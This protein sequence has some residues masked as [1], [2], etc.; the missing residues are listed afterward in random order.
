VYPFGFGLSYADVEEK[1]IDENTVEI[2]NRSDID[3]DYSVLKFQQKPDLKLLDFKK[4]KLKGNSKKI[5][6]FG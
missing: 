6:K 3:T 5:V 2:S 4:V 1:W